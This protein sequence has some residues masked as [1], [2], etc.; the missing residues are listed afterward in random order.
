MQRKL[1]SER[2]FGLAATVGL[3]AGGAAASGQT[4]TV[5]ANNCWGET[6][7]EAFATDG[8]C[9]A[10]FPGNSGSQSNAGAG[11]TGGIL[12]ISMNASHDNN[13]CCSRSYFPNVRS[14]YS[15]NDLVI[16]GGGGA[17][18]TAQCTLD[19]YA[20]HALSHDCNC[21]EFSPDLPGLSY[22]RAIFGA[23]N[24]DD[25]VLNTPTNGWHSLTWTGQINTFFP[26]SFWN[27]KLEAELD[28]GIVGRDQRSDGSARAIALL[29]PVN[30]D[31][32]I[33][34]VFTFP[35]CPGCTAN[36]ASINLI[37]NYIYPPVGTCV[38]DIDGDNDTDLGDF[39]IL[40]ANFGATSLFP[41]SDGDLD[42]DQDCDLADFTRLA[43]N[44]GC[45]D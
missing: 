45:S 14:L 1:K 8:S 38:A 27:V 24:S 40:A 19:M 22:F 20:F 16:S 10:S 36:A 29:G 37:D 26:T 6:R 39:T 3:L 42:Y 4:F 30:P 17:I 23:T 32:S 15:I 11:S 12:R 9:H 44:F 2:T 25:V 31:G 28:L 21:G 34:P 35:D 18:V 33:G 5:G 43:S 7:T 41:G 13:G